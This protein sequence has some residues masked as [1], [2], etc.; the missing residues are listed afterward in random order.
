MKSLIKN[1]YKTGDFHLKREKLNRNQLVLFA[2]LV[3]LSVILKIMLIP[4]NM[5]NGEAVTRV[6]NA[7]WWS[8]APFII[9]PSVNHP[10]YYYLMG[11][12]IYVFREIY[13]VPILTSITIVTISG[14]YLFKTSYLI[15][16]YKIALLTYFIFTFN[17]AS[18][19][20]NFD[21]HPYSLTPLFYTITVYYLLRAF[22]ESDSKRHFFIAGVFTFLA[23]F[24]R[25]E[26]IFVIVCFCSI[27]LLSGKKGYAVY[28]ILSLWFQVFWIML[29]LYLYGIPF[30]TFTH[31]AEYPNLFDI[32]GLNLA[33]RTKGFFLPYYF[34]LMG[35]T[36]PVFYFFAKGVYLIY[37]KYPK[38]VFI[39]LIIPL[40]VSALSTGAA[41]I[42]ATTFHS[43]FYIFPM[44]YF[45]S[46][47][48]AFGLD[49]FTL[50]FKSTFSRNAIASLVIIC[51][52]PLSYLKDFV[53]QKYKGLF[54][55]VVQF[56]E[57][58]PEPSETRTLCT[59]IDEHIDE[60]P[61]LILDNEGVKGTVILYLAYRTKLA[62]PDKILITTYNIPHDMLSLTERVKIF[63]SKNK[64]GIFLVR[65]NSTLFSRILHDPKIIE[66]WNLNL[67]NFRKTI[68]WSIYFY[69][70]KN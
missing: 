17:P 16:D 4:Y 29:S 19:R 43:T 2:A 25:P 59:I 32:H 10:F 48:A 31:A 69:E 58:A 60:Y 34:L 14:V 7:L 41:S 40:L 65:N 47:F 21:P 42:S 30:A 13:Y 3:L 15:S 33:L 23:S 11:P 37:K 5:M 39:T 44:F 62:P 8:Q 36:L 50:K 26:A 24:S 55:K 20:L 53:P 28:I 45:G 67:N 52:I 57:T 51:A 56:F 68:H 66:E 63:V 9:L 64:R 70:V 38:I 46:V 61:S 27:A 49:K 1:L 22:F 54:P 12:L 18:F 6:W 35:M